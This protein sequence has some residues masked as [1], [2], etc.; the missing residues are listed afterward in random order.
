MRLDGRWL[1]VIPQA[2]LAV[3]EKEA[4]QMNENIQF[5][6]APQIHNSS[7]NHNQ[8]IIPVSKS[9]WF[10]WVARSIAPQPIRIGRILL[11]SADDIRDF[12]ERLLEQRKVPPGSNQIKGKKRAKS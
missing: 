11:W 3:L 10:Q 7:Q 6:R 12:A 1:G 4:N 8:G 2:S 5:L 9:L